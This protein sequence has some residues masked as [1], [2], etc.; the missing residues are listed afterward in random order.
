MSSQIIS[1]VG[2]V[3]LAELYYPAGRVSQATQSFFQLMF[4]I[5]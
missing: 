2:G 4:N 5:L 3:L 1:A